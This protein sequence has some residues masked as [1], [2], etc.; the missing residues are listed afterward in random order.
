MDDWK[1]P[2]LAPLSW[3]FWTSAAFA[4]QDIGTFDVADSQGCLVEGWAKDPQSTSPVWVDVYVDG[5]YGA[6]GRFLFGCTANLYR[7]DLPYTD[8]NHGFDCHVPMTSGIYDGQQ[9]SLYIYGDPVAAGTTSGML[10]LSPKSIQCAVPTSVNATQFGATGDGVHDDSGAIQ[11]AIQTVAPSGQVTI[12]AGTF[13][14][15]SGAQSAQSTNGQTGTVGTYPNGQAIR[16]AIIISK[17]GVTISGAGSSTILM[18]QPAVKMRAIS[19]ASSA[20]N[21]TISNLV[22]DGNKANRNASNGWPNGDVVDTLLIGWV[23]SG[24][25]ISSVE[26]RNGIEDGVG[27][28]QCDQVTYANLHNH[29]NGTSTAGGS[30][31]SYSGRNGVI[32]NSTFSGNT[33]PGI[34]SAFGTDTITIESNTITNNGGAAISIGGQGAGLVNHDANYTVTGNTMTGNGLSGFAA[35]EIYSATNGSISGNTID[36]NVSGIRIQH[37]PGT[38]VSSGWTISNNQIE[39]T[40]SARLQSAGISIEDT[41]NQIQISNN[42]CVNNGVSLADQIVIAPTA[43]ATLTGNTVSYQP[44]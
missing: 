13:M 31:A 36:D 14:L 12:P 34:W 43:S 6:G 7:S 25:T 42:T 3:L 4:A 10:N 16:S 5:P 24:M 32:R 38:T 37:A 29:D 19:V 9:H 26:S 11:S 30:G 33:A 39:N 17:S 23:A 21:V 22:I 1:L 15:G 18:L 44:P 35:I 40:S 27:C 41:S 8:K 28:W 2:L 20:A